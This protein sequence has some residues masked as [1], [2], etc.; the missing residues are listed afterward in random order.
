MKLNKKSIK[1]IKIES[2]GLTRQTWKP[3]HETDNN[4]IKNSNVKGLVTRVGRP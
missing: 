1:K 2:I 4:P 3:D